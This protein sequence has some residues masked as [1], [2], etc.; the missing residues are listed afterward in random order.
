M[1]DRK[2]IQIAAVM[3]YKCNSHCRYCPVEHTNL[4]LSKEHLKKLTRLLDKTEYSE[5]R[6]DFLG[7]EPLTRWE[8]IEWA[9]ELTKN[10]LGDRVSFSIATNGILLDK[11][12]LKFM[13]DHDFNVKVSCEGDRET[14]ISSRMKEGLYTWEQLAERHAHLIEMLGTGSGMH[15]NLRLGMV[16]LPE[17]SDKVFSNYTFL[18]STGSQRVFVY[19]VIGFPWSRKSIENLDQQL[20]K[21]RLHVLENERPDAGQIN[22]LDGEIQYCLNILGE[23][24][25][26]YRGDD[27]LVIDADGNLYADEFIGIPVHKPD[28]HLRHIDV[29]GE[30]KTLDL[31]SKITMQQIY[32]RKRYSPKILKGLIDSHTILLRHYLILKNIVA[33]N[34]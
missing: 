7:G 29:T 26:R 1:T 21:V 2:R 18:S 6:F 23:I 24:V 34:E 31:N 4:S 15:M 9:V 17:F 22:T 20:N 11:D 8:I 19:P 5:I 14:Y 27:M 25:M 30:I 28:I 13:A 12:K 32:S 10:K 3:T 16:T 33:E